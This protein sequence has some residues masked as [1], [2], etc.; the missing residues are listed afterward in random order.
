M[1]QFD[2]SSDDYRC[3]CSCFHVISL[4]NLLNWHIQL[5][6]NGYTVH[7]RYWSSIDTLLLLE[8]PASSSSTKT[9]LR[10]FRQEWR[11]CSS[12]LYRDCCLLWNFYPHSPFN[13][14]RS[15]EEFR[16]ASL[17]SFD[18]AIHGYSNSTGTSNHWTD[19]HPYKFSFL[20]SD[21]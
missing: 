16:R 13:D 1:V 7:S 21:S 3:F 18:Y 9:R 8:C 19:C 2:E 6:K 17:G 15:Y 12:C 5:D 20:L 14:R 11:L 4:N 10:S